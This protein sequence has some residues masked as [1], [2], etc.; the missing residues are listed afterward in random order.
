MN[1]QA[2]GR[3]AGGVRATVAGLTLVAAVIYIGFYF[4]VAAR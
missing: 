2:D 4:L 1:R 3:R